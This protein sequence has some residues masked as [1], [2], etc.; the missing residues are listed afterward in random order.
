MNTLEQ[1]RRQLTEGEFDFSQHAFRRA[2]ERNVSEQE[3]REAGADAIIVEE[4]LEDKYG[5]SSVVLGFTHWGGRS[6]FK[7]PSPAR[8]GSELLHS[9]DQPKMNGKTMPGGGSRK[10]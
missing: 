7:C 8:L 2:V 6:I 9:M 3:I 1:V 5:P 10:C 4:Y